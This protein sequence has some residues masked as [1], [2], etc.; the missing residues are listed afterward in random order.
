MET[1]HLKLQD[2][3][4]IETSHLKLLFYLSNRWLVV[5]YPLFISMVL[6]RI[7][8]TNDRN[9]WIIKYQTGDG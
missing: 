1:S 6:L 3:E 2:S 9:Q 5:T 4:N 8:T 7:P